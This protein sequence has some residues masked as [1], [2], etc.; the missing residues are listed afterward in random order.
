MLGAMKT[1]A[2]A[3]G[4]WALVAMVSATEESAVIPTLESVAL[5]KNGLTVVRASFAV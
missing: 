3:L 2:I 4:L 1:T 5:F